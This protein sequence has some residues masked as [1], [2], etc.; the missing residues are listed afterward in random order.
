MTLEVAKPAPRRRTTKRAP[1]KAAAPAP[2]PRPRAARTATARAAAPGATGLDSVAEPALELY[3]LRHADAGDSTTWEGDD[4]ARPLSKKGR[5]QARRLGRHL[6]GLG[7]DVSTILT[8]PRVRA[9]DTARLI[10]KA[11]G[12]KPTTDP[13]VDSG[14]DQVA[15]EAIV[16]DLDAAATSVI[17]V[18]HDPDFSAIASWLSAS[19]VEMR[20]GAIAKIDLPGRKVGRGA[21]VLRWLLPPDALRG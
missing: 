1:D 7:I 18:G 6:G 4:A 17:L 13:R 10:G 8:S 3:L 2:A 14:F 20:K 15:L 12:V 9:A 16:G 19:T 21:G 11:L 5:K